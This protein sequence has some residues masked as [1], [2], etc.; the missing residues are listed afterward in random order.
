MLSR[1][2]L[3]FKMIDFSNSIGEVFYVVE[4]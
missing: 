1:I 3:D 2:G 4:S